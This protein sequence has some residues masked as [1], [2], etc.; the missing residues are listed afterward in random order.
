MKKCFLVTGLIFSFLMT[1]AQE[2][3]PS[4]KKDWSKA[5]LTNRPKDH[6]MFQLGYLGWA[7]APDSIATKG[8]AR[9]FNAYFIFDFPFK[10]DARFSVGIGVGFGTDHMF[11]D[12]GARRDLNITNPTTFRFARNT[13]ADTAISYKKIKLGT[14]Y[15]EAPVELRFM[16]KPETPNKSLKFALGVKVGTM[17]SAVDKT[18]FNRDASGNVD[19]SRKDKSRVHFN[20]LRLA[21]TA[22]IGY[23]NIGLFAQ[24]QLNDFIKEG[25]GPNTIRPFIIGLVFTGL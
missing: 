4:K 11:F 23:G 21:P 20:G 7:Q 18:K 8:L 9:S 25:Q 19:F 24:Y 13:G 14:A 10:T 22:R 12:N 3:T 2:T 6:L 16:T 15:L 5:N 17:L 1:Q